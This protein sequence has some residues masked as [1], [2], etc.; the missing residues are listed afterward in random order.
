MA[1]SNRYSDASFSN[2]K[3]ALEPAVQLLVPV[4]IQAEERL[5][6]KLRKEGRQESMEFSISF[7]VIGA[8][9]R[10]KRRR[11]AGFNWVQMEQRFPAYRTTK[12]PKDGAGWYRGSWECDEAARLR[13][14]EI[15]TWL[16]WLMAAL[17]ALQNSDGQP[18][19]C[20]G[21][22]PR[23]VK[24]LRS[25]E[26]RKDGRG[27]TPVVALQVVPEELVENE[28]AVAEEQVVVMLAYHL[29]VSI[30][31]V[32]SEVIWMEIVVDGDDVDDVRAYSGVF[33]FPEGPID[34]GVETC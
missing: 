31:H 23:K 1:R 24:W 21:H 19:P 22:G 34:L 4:Q 30:S 16:P 8:F 6:E 29:E 5:L 28:L 17:P 26:L 3:I 15:A 11:S 2:E 32:T 7:I 33:V 9:K 20:H 27:A 14:A 12:L 13:A 10:Y 18:F 25:A